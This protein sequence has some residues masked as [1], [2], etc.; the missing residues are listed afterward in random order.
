MWTDRL[1][2]TPLTTPAADWWASKTSSIALSDSRS[3]VDESMLTTLRFL[4]CEKLKAGRLLVEG[5]NP[6]N[7][8]SDGISFSRRVRRVYDNANHDE[9]SC[10]IMIETPNIGGEETRTDIESAFGF[11]EGEGNLLDKDVHINVDELVLKYVPSVTYFFG[12]KFGVFAFTDTNKRVTVVI[13]SRLTNAKYHWM[14]AV[15]P[16]LLPWFWADENGKMNVDRRSFGL[17]EALNGTDKELY[18]HIVKD[19]ADSLG[20]ENEYISERLKDFLTS[21]QRRTIENANQEIH[22]MNYQIDS[23]LDAIGDYVRKINDKKAIIMGLE[24]AIEDA[25]SDEFA[26]YIR[27]NRAIRTEDIGSDRM[28]ITCHG[29]M[30]YYDTEP[31]EKMLEDKRSLIYRN[32]EGGNLRGDKIGKLLKAIFID[33]SIRLLTVA[34]YRIDIS[35]SRISA[36]S[37]VIDYSS[38]FMDYLPNPHIEHHGCIGDYN[39]TMAQ[40]VRDGNYIGAVE[41]CIASAQTMNF[42][43]STV[44]GELIRDLSNNYETRKCI[45]LPDGSHTTIKGAMEYIDA[46]TQE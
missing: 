37:G 42:Y 17:L 36:L 25:N 1:G 12:A 19:Y 9:D 13:T 2:Q 6:G 23:W 32:A 43:D 35:R 38:E 33:E 34:R 14:Q 27:N 41:Q 45:V 39:I 4:F 10:L 5:S 15:M 31:L 16:M 8:V 21:A 40:Y 30:T 20:F 3:C 11:P 46:Q 29:E 44:T 28:V 7:R 24:A 26:S 18:L 22:D